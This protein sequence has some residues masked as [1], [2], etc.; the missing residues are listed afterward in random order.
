MIDHSA[1]PPSIAQAALVE[2]EF[3]I[4]ITAFLYLPEL[5][6]FSL[7]GNIY[8]D[9]RGK[10]TDGRLI[11][12]SAVLE[13]LQCAG[14]HIACTFSGSRYVLLSASGADVSH[15]L[16]GRFEENALHC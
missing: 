15:L 13:F 6:G 5:D 16:S 10:F 4:S 11:R 8:C 2:F 12:T 14:Y 3:E 1:R 7:V 9:R